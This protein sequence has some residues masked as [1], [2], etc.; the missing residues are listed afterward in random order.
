MARAPLLAALSLV[1][2]LAASGCPGRSTPAGGEPTTPAPGSAAGEAG[3]APRIDL[4]GLLGRTGPATIGLPARSGD[5]VAV[6]LV[7]GDGGRGNPNLTLALLRAGDGAVDREIAILTADE[8]EETAEEE[9]R[10]TVAGRVEA[11]NR[12]L[13]DDAFVPLE[14]VG[15]AGAEALDGDPVRLLGGGLSIG[16][17][18][19]HAVVRQEGGPVLFD[20]LLEAPVAA[21]PDS[22]EPC[23]ATRPVVTGA[24]VDRDRT[25]VVFRLL[26]IGPEMC[27]EPDTEMSLR[28]LGPADE[29]HAYGPDHVI[30]CARFDD[31]AYRA[32]LVAAG[33]EVEGIECGEREDE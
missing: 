12:L 15:E 25:L 29:A 14:L 22:D 6:T 8:F 1:V 2:L 13:A 23:A 21:D 17:V 4:D 28:S 11:A 9:L 16:I 33:V 19:G 31:V 3:P 30:D 20:A 10:A 7:H 26:E 27:G 18:D 24:W 32:R 5:L